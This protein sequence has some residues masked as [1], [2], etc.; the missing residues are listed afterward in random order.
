M[1]LT[2][3][4]RITTSY[5]LKAIF[6]EQPLQTNSSFKKSEVARIYFSQSL[7]LKTLASSKEYSSS[8]H[9]LS[10]GEGTENVRL[11]E[12]QQRLQQLLLILH[13]SSPELRKIETHFEEVFH[14]HLAGVIDDELIVVKGVAIG[15]YHTRFLS[16]TQRNQGPVPVSGG[17]KERGCERGHP[18]WKRSCRQDSGLVSR[19]QRS[20]TSVPCWEKQSAE[21]NCLAEK[22]RV[23]SKLEK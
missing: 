22:N 18:D 2:Q 8:L 14:A 3:K 17:G 23:H 6:I 12:N 1:Q 7:S 5:R 20:A 10:Q 19:S 21:G 13:R 11:R 15:V 16:W 4:Q 9:S